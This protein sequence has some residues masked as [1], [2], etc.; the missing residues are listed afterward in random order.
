MIGSLPI[1]LI[2]SLVF[3]LG[4]IIVGVLPAYYLLAGRRYRE[5]RV[6]LM[7]FVG[8]WFVGSGA[9]ELFV[10]GMESSQRL[11][12]AP[13]AVTFALWRSHA[14]STL[15]VVTLT[16]ALGMAAYLVYLAALRWRRAGDTAAAHDSAR[17]HAAKIEG[18]RSGS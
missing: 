2:L 7:T 16:L 6:V 15:L 17:E 18:E 4:Q 14:D 10:S 3:G 13:T 11:S 5:W 9:I 8:L 12:G 1:N